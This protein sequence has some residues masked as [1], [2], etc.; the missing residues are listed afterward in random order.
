MKNEITEPVTTYV[1]SQAALKVI[2]SLKINFDA[3]LRFR[4]ALGKSALLALLDI[5]SL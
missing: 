2:E 4:T 1:D 3:V 5:W